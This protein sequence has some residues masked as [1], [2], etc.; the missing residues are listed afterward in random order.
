MPKETILVIEDDSDIVEII[1][2][3][4][5]REG[6]RVI[7]AS[8]GEKG[9]DAVVSR[10]VAD[11]EAAPLPAEWNALRSEVLQAGRSQA[12]PVRQDEVSVEGQQRMTV[13][14]PLSITISFGT[15]STQPD[16]VTAGT[17]SLPASPA[18]T[19]STAP[20]PDYSHRPGY[21]A[22]FVGFDAPLPALTD[23]VKGDAFTLPD[24]GV[25]LKYF[26]CSVIFNQA[27]RIAFVSAVNLDADA[28][29]ES[30]REGADKWFYDPRVPKALQAGNEFYTDNPL[31]RGHLTRR[32]DAAWGAT[33]EEAD[34]SNSDTFHWTNC[35]PQHEVFNQSA[36]AA[37]KHVKLWGTIEN[38]IALQSKQGHLKVSV[39]NGPILRSD[40]RNHRGL[41]VPREFW[42][43]VVYRRDNGNP[44]AGA[45]VL[46]QA[47]LIN[48][49]PAEEFEPG[50]YQ[51]YQVKL[52]D[53]ANKTKLDFGPL[54]AFDVLA[55]PEHEAFVE[56][57]H[58]PMPV[59]RLQ[60]VRL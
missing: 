48:D 8:N 54:V 52:A 10:L 6:Y 35:S 9:I 31:D 37:Q 41:Q 20:E 17:V 1:Q 38:Y 42:K 59:V 16:T 24:A 51:T 2:Y 4:F 30:Q 58:G 53:L 15:P 3:N 39:L 13:T 25:E 44:G 29:F 26:H 14:V 57:A 50:P 60:T 46:S 55:T 47:S 12:A 22:H 45:F 11:I 33:E 5:E 23:A 7:T 28:E 43:V 34:R 56:A 18:A 21:D 32:A 49:L 19:E 27:R 36:K 40:D